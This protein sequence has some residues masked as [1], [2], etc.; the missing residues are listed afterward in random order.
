MTDEVKLTE[1][2]IEKRKQEIA[3][4]QEQYEEL[5]EANKKLVKEFGA[6]PLGELDESLK[7]NFYTFQRGHFY[8]HR[9]FDQYMKTLKS[10]KKVAIAT[11]VNASG[12]LHIG[13]KLVFDTILYFQKEYQIPCFI[14]ISDDESYVAGKVKDQEE[15]LMNSRILA[16]EL[17]AYG[18]DPNFTFFIIDQIYT[19]IYNLAI[20]LSR[21]TTLSMLKATYGYSMEDNCGLFFYPA[22]QSAHILMPQQEEHGDHD[23]VLVPIGPDEDAH[24]R[25][26]RDL[27]PKFG[28]VK[29]AI[30][31]NI[32]IPGLKGGKM[33][34]T[35]PNSA[36]FLEDDPK[37]A[38]AKVMRAKTGG[39]ESVEMQRKY[40][41]DYEI[42]V[43]YK[44]LDV[45]F[46]NNA[47]REKLK[48]ECKSGEILCKDCKERLAQNIGAMLEEF[49]QNMKK[50]DKE[51]VDKCIL[52]N[53]Y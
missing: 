22:V 2:Q 30:L 32:F 33:A 9:D 18:F 39:R 46:L 1:E 40:G 5:L 20:K 52:R 41:A 50:I 17:L 12:K 8:S 14:P 6:T 4:A 38:K 45:F 27:A 53:H 26:G 44:Y 28:F 25:I 13:H 16:K 11:G 36:V 31:H 19:N 29:P 42:C 51:H 48:K 47:E 10:R 23:H 7:P 43:V 35:D 21:G 24:I 15:G 3:E 49:Q 34:T 37:T